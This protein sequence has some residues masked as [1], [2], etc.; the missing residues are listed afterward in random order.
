[1]L[2]VRVHPQ[3]LM[4]IDKELVRKVAR[5]SR[6]EINERELKKFAEDFKEV[7][8][9]FSKLKKINTDDVEPTFLGF[10]LMSVMRDDISG[11]CLR[12]KYVFL[13][14]EN[15]EN[16]FFKGPKTL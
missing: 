3:T 10:E 7:L 8:A 15:K 1:V 5:I 12:A 9:D 2:V 13:N 11:K 16:G 14:T 4:K 6:I